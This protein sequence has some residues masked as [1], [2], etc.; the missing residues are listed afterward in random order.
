VI[1]EHVGGRAWSQSRRWL[2][3]SAS[4]FEGQYQKVVA[5]SNTKLESMA[6]SSSNPPVHTQYYF[7][8]QSPLLSATLQKSNNVGGP[9]TYCVNPLRPH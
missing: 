7:T 6:L 8:T 9:T 4:V 5:P 1:L 2:R 3:S